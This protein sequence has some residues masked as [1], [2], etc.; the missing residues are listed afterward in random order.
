MRTGRSV[1]ERPPMGRAVVLVRN[2]VRHDS[3]VL[4]E[5]DTLHRLGFDVTVVGVVGS[6]DRGEAFEHG[7]IRVVRLAP[8][9]RLGRFVGRLR[10]RN[11]PLA[12]VAADGPASQTAGGALAGPAP[13]SAARGRGSLRRLTVT[14]LYYAAGIRLVLRSRPALVHANDYNTMWIGLAAKLLR[15]SRLVYDS[16]ELWADRNRRPEW[17][18]W[19]IACEWLFVRLADVTITT[20]PGY[21]AAIAR[22]YRV[23]EP[24]VVRNIPAR[25][26]E[27]SLPR[28]RQAGVPTVAY[29]GAVTT[30][31]GLEQ[32]IEA[33]AHVPALHLTITGPGTASYRGELA[34][35]AEAAG[36]ADRVDLRE[37]VEPGRTVEAIAGADFGLL[38][39]QPVCLS[40]ELTLPNKLFEYAAGGL[41]M[42][43]SD[44]EVIGAL[45]RAE[46]LGEVVPPADVASIAAGMLRLLEPD[47]NRSARDRVAAFDAANRWEH[48]RTVLARA[49]SGDSDSS[50]ERTRVAAVYDGYGASATKRRSWDARNPGNV[51]IRG[52]LQTAI[53][54]L[55]GREV[56]SARAIL[57][58]GCG[59]GWW[60]AELAADADVAADLHGVELLAERA[61]AAAASA[62]EARIETAD[63]R[64]LPF[65]ADAFDVVTMF[66]T[67][68]SLRTRAD[69]DRALREAIRVLRPGGIV[70]VWEPRMPNPFNPATRLIRRKVLTA[71]T[72]DGRSAIVPVTLLP[73]LARR[74]G[75]HTARL[76]PALAAVPGLRTH[77]LFIGRRHDEPEAVNR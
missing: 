43:T 4:R 53:S 7:G 44:L 67:L 32:A 68:S 51:A 1:D 66:T 9:A 74:L 47:V 8:G 61:C 17:R 6:A 71:A 3:R 15:G 65:D 11:A 20:S 42:L 21:A 13:P 54:A 33:L 60:L 35:L 34:A 18:P 38:L 10:S 2:T 58:V 23:P 29:L 19:L 77:R 75:M 26:G 48:E 22:R 40:Y 24:V 39:I 14:A 72:G 57:D 41:P 36:V 27:P 49:Y 25:P 37:A 52:E 69:V 63:A 31:R 70:I 64:E 59:T 62:P 56:Q 73:P 5:A 55:A 12:V 28:S 30:G 76:Y 45:V 50:I 16:H 46:G